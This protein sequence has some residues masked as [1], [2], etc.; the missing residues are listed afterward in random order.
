MD[1]R[2]RFDV[3]RSSPCRATEPV[4]A[5]AGRDCGAG[6][7]DCGAGD[8]CFAAWLGDGEIRCSAGYSRWRGG[9][10][11]EYGY[12]CCFAGSAADEYS[13][14]RYQRCQWWFELVGRP[15]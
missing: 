4:S 11:L 12:R 7:F 13:E 9:G 5:V 14:Y 1:Y 3:G 2:Q 8:C 10:Q 15:E 6:E